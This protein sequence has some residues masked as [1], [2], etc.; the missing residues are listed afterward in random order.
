M[1][2][3]V[4]Q[5]LNQE[6]S[7][8]QNGRPVPSMTS[9]VDEETT[10]TSTVDRFVDTVSDKLGLV[11]AETKVSLKQLQ[12]AAK[13]NAAYKKAMAA[14]KTKMTIKYATYLVIVVLVVGIVY[15]AYKGIT[16]GPNGIKM[17]IRKLT[18]HNNGYGS[19][20]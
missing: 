20:L 14:N 9:E 2:D 18:G 8:R 5:Y 13:T 1:A 12:L 3:P 15:I 4:D 19:S 7:V 11:D 10:S 17:A 6:V 16:K